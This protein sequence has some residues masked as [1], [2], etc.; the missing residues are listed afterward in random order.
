MMDTIGWICFGIAVNALIGAGVLAAVDRQGHLFEW[1]KSAPC[2]L[3]K[4]LVLELWFVVLAVYYWP[5]RPK[6]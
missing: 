2:S 5:T 3:L 1:Y 4:G 6:P